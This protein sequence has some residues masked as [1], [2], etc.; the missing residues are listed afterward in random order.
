MGKKFQPVIAN[1]DR[2]LINDHCLQIRIQANLEIL[3]IIEELL[4]RQLYQ[5]DD[6]LTNLREKLTSHYG[7]FVKNYGYLSSDGSKSE[8]GKDP[9]Y[10]LIFSLEVNG[11]KATI[12]T[13]RTT[14]GYTV[15]SKCDTPKDA[16]LH[17]LNIKGKV[18]LD[19][20]SA[21]VK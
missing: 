19:W 5:T 7:K 17:C 6:A 12:F 18:D 13:Q 2:R 21:R 15:P 4:D 1:Y 3:Y 9:R 8:F 16:L 20:I 10:G 14:R 11:I